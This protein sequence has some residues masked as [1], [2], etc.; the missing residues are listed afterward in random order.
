MIK[1]LTEGVCGLSRLEPTVLPREGG[2]W[3]L[4]M[5]R[6]NPI[7][8]IGRNVSGSLALLYLESFL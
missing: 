5:F 4:K 8:K 2:G 3:E 6:L 1:F 7:L